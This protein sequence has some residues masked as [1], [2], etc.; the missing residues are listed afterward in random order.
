[1]RIR[2]SLR[3]ITTSA[4]AVGLTAA[5]LVVAAG[6]AN[7]EVRT[8]SLR[9]N[10]TF[11][12]I[13]QQSVTVTVSADLPA[14]VPV[15]TLIP[16]ITV[17]TSANA[18]RNAATALRLV[19]ARTIDGA[20]TAGTR[21]TA[22]GVDLNLSVPVTIPRQNVASPL[23]LRASGSAPAVQFPQAGTA[24]I[25]VGEIALRGLHPRTS[26]GGDTALGVFDAPCTQVAG[27][28]TLLATVQITP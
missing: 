23:V 11:P 26:S 1:M 5:G 4:L 13:G 27:Q 2:A 28:N 8:L 7:A 9:Y 20:A 21:L 25:N 24:S 6:S 18:G 12:L 19:G 17:N 15:N 10:C 3:K 16:P 14:S 22:P